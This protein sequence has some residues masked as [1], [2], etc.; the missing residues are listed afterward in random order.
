MTVAML[1]NNIHEINV[2][3]ATG[4]YATKQSGLNFSRVGFLSPDLVGDYSTYT[5]MEIYV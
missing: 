3:T 1:L 4:L 5:F 2:R